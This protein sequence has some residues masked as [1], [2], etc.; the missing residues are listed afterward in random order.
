[1]EAGDIR[2]V[3][4]GPGVPCMQLTGTT[5]PEGSG[6]SNKCSSRGLPKY[7]L[8]CDIQQLWFCTAVHK[9]K[10]VKVRLTYIAPHLRVC[11]LQRR[12]RHQWGRRI[13]AQTNAHGLWPLQPYRRTYRSLPLSK[14]IHAHTRSTTH[15]RTPE[16]WKAELA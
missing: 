1:M 8:I 7:S 6:Y 12:C 9:V 15:L 5:V 14:V 13:E 2:I 3:N 10:L 16:G 4:G 11:C